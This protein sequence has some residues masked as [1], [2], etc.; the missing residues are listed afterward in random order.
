[1]KH[2][3]SYELKWKAIWIKQIIRDSELIQLQIKCVY[4]PKCKINETPKAF[5]IKEH[6]YLS[7]TP[8]F[9]SEVE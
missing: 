1:M 7:R 5:F 4:T 6:N 8:V 9:S 3:N 2:Q